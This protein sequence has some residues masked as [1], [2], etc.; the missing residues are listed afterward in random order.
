MVLKEPLLPGDP[1][2]AIAS[3]S[4]VRLM[5]R[6]LQRHDPAIGFMKW[7]TGAFYL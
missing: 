5:I 1:G 7:D 3:Q 6:A 2:F 4:R